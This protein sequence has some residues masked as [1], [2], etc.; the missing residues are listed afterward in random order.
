MKIFHPHGNVKIAIVKFYSLLLLNYLVLKK[1][2][3]CKNKIF[4]FLFTQLNA[5]N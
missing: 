5:I 2:I 3:K 4:I 1:L